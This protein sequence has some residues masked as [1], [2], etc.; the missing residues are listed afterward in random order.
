M[1]VA[2]CEEAIVD[3]KEPSEDPAVALIAGRIGFASPCD[4]MSSAG[5][6]QLVDI[7]EAEVDA[8]VRL[9]A[10]VVQ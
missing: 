2:A 5:W 9:K 8:V 7:C 10:D 3:G 1:L 6:Q 4:L